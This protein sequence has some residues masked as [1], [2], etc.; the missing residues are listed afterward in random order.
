VPKGETMASYAKALH[1]YATEKGLEV[2][3]FTVDSCLYCADPEKELARLCSMV[4]IA[5]E[6]GIP[7]MR[8]DIA[9]KF[10]GDEP[11]KSPKK[12]IETA[13][14]YVRRL[15]EYAKEKKVY[16]GLEN[17]ERRK[18][19]LVYTIDD[20]NR[21]AEFGKNN[22]Y[23]G[24]TLDFA[25]FSSHGILKPDLSKLKLPI[26]NVHLSQ[27]LNGKMHVPLTVE[28]GMVDMKSVCEVLKNYNYDSLVVFEVT[29][30]HVEAKRI[31]EE[32]MRQV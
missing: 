18:H 24:V 6:L 32:T 4:D 2:P 10:I 5:S 26:H 1:A 7:L 9:Y 28:N 12:V 27:G 15:A 17:M 25:H 20:L 16:I 3:I 23:F 30:D 21:F 11:S 13:A 22:P 19:E 14:P 29:D 8:F 31:L